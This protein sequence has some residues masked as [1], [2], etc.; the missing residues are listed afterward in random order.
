MEMIFPPR[1]RVSEPRVNSSA[2]GCAVTSYT[3][4]HLLL[5][6]QH[7]VFIK[8]QHVITNSSFKRAARSTSSF[9]VLAGQSSTTAGQSDRPYRYQALALWVLYLFT[10]RKKTFLKKRRWW[11][12]FTAQSSFAMSV[13]ALDLRKKKHHVSNVSFFFFFSKNITM[14]RGTSVMEA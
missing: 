7:F 11:H 5:V 13:G 2:S 12:H 10:K 4:T 14:K 9:F 1:E 6:E 3:N 8:C